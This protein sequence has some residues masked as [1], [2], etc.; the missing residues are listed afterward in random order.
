MGPSP[1]SVKKFE[2]AL[3]DNGID[4][5]VTIYDGVGHAFIKRKDHMDGKKTPVTAWN[6]IENFLKNAFRSS[7]QSGRRALNNFDAN[8]N[9]EYVIPWHVSLY[10]RFMCAR[11]CSVDMFTHTGHWS[12]TGNI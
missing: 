9:Q 5:N 10:H 4:H 12:N 6:E 1:E 2:N 8:V 7:M 11:K 3:D